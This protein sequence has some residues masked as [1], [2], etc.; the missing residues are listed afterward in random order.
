MKKLLGALLLL[1]CGCGPVGWCKI[2]EIH[3]VP[4]HS[5]FVACGSGLSYV[6]YPTTRWARV[7]GRDKRGNYCTREIFLTED[8]W[9]EYK[10]H[11]DKQVFVG[12]PL[13]IPD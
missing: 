2:L 11:G 13:P 1:T 10:L 3:T 6:S 8:E 12:K 7:G 4:A 5:S 9:R